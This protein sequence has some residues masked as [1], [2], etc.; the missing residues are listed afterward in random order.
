VDEGGSKGVESWEDIG[1]WMAVQQGVMA[2]HWSE[3][4]GSVE[5]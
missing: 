3:M 4:R 5:E 1:G 2:G